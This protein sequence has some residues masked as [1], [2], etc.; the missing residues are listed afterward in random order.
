MSPGEQPGVTPVSKVYF[1]NFRTTAKL[2]LLQKLEKLVKQAGIDAIDFQNKYVAIKV[3][4][5]EP[6]NLAYLRPNY[7]KV[8]VDMVR[9]RGGRPFL[10][11]CNTLYIGRRKNA[12][13]HLD[14]AYENGFSPFSTG[15]HIII[16][17]GLKGTDE[18]LIDLAGFSALVSCRAGGRGLAAVAAWALARFPWES[19]GQGGNGYVPIAPIDSRGA[20]C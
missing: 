12:L 3:H 9:A 4:F 20:P 2:N 1:T 19:E 10:T 13:D 17:D 11:D 16:G 15:C 18:V 8:L 7:A 6:G 5:G 14:A